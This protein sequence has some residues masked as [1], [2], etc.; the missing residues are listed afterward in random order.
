MAAWKVL[1]DGVQQNQGTQGHRQGYLRAWKA[2][3]PELI[4]QVSI[5]NG[6]FEPEYGDF[7]GPGMVHIRQ[8]EAL[9][10]QF[11][12]HLQGGNF[13]T[14]RGFPAF[15]PDVNK[16]DSYLAYEDSYTDGPYRSPGKYRRDNINANYTRNL[17]ENQKFGMRFIFG[18]KKFYSSGQIPLDL[19]ES[20]KLERFGFI[21]PSN[22]G[23]VKPGKLSAY[24]S[25]A[26]ANG[27]TFRADG[28]LRRS[29]FDLNL[30]FTFFT[31]IRFM[32]RAGRPRVFRR[33][34]MLV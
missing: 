17:S 6:P 16:V 12:A 27:D 4:Q 11:T 26:F 19:V 18:R 9:P 20:G 2:L 15:N 5:I 8:T 24:Y 31:I 29:L 34:P 1:V 33:W 32:Q 25:R 14:G 21:D 3:S 30:N 10:D 13:D 22:G 23:R 28:F 7:S